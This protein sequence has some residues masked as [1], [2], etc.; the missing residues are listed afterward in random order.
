MWPSRRE[1]VMKC[2]LLVQ[3]FTLHSLVIL[4]RTRRLAIIRFQQEMMRDV[5]G[6]TLSVLLSDF[7]GDDKL[8]LIVGNDYGPPDHY[9]VGDGEGGFAPILRGDGRVPVTTFRA[10]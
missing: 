7:T 9:Y 6:E 5:V 3:L 4:S 8:D 10:R 1:V 2:Q